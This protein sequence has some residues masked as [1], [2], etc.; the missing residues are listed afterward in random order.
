MEA[1]RNMVFPG[2]TKNTGQVS[3]KPP[4][5][6]R[7]LAALS[8]PR[9]TAAVSVV[10]VFA[11]FGAMNFSAAP[12]RATTASA[13]VTAMAD[14]QAAASRNRSG[15]SWAS[16][17]YLPDATPAAA[18]AFGAWRGHPLDVVMAW[19]KQSTWADITDP[20]W[21]YK[22]WKGSPYTMAF[23]VAMLPTKVRGV[24][25]RSCA[26]GAYNRYWKQFGRVI[27]SYGLGHSIIR[28][29]WEFNGPWYRWKASDP[30]AWAEGW[31]QIV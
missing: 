29:G 30:S 19:L 27:R 6:G 20:A 12:A 9:I 22:R 31:R 15:L 17:A 28:L 21:L 14:V 11:V 13:H 5:A 18:S 16:G 25:I 4:A 1:L 2:E 24:S 8:H 26:Y 7:G 10:C 3:A 23:S